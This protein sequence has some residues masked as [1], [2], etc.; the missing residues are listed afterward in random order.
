MPMATPMI[1][2]RINALGIIAMM[3][4][5]FALSIAL[6]KHAEIIKMDRPNA[7]IKYNFQR[8]FLKKDMCDFLL[9]Q[10]TIPLSFIAKIKSP[11]FL[12]GTFKN[13]CAIYLARSV[14]NCR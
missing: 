2:K 13:I 4:D 5:V 7:S 12:V 1:S 9:G 6:K 8:S 14:Y 11:N 3:Q 10:F